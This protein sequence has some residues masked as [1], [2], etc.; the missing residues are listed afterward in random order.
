MTKR[1]LD[2]SVGR[3]DLEVG[4]PDVLDLRDDTDSAPSLFDGDVGRSA[5]PELRF[6]Q[7]LSDPVLREQALLDAVVD[8]CAEGIVPDATGDP[9]TSTWCR[10]LDVLAR[11]GERTTYV[12]TFKVRIDEAVAVAAT[13]SAPDR[14]IAARLL[15]DRTAAVAAN[16][17][18]F[19]HGVLGARR[20]DP[21]SVAPRTVIDTVQ[22]PCLRYGAGTAGASTVSFGLS[23]ALAILASGSGQC[24]NA[25]DMWALRAALA[26]LP[27]SLHGPLQ[28]QVE[29]LTGQDRRIL[30]TLLTP[31]RER[32]LW[33]RRSREGWEKLEESLRRGQLPSNR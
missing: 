31:E 28:I 19:R 30:D 22:R 16:A 10:L 26:T 23:V 24:I 12:G 13:L 3:P 2:R 4:A 32:H 9:R 25:D 21:Q 17:R 20:L 6:L 1:G 33:R 27:T 5:S 11:I 29:K 14:A 15:L 18:D 8:L 7:L